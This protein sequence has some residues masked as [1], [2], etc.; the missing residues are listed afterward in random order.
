MHFSCVCK[1]HGG[2]KV[3]DT[4]LGIAHKNALDNENIYSNYHLLST[5][6][7]PGTGPSV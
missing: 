1:G 5:Y 4:E 6:S 7:V 3:Q 2:E